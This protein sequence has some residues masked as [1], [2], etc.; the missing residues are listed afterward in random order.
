M[1]ALSKVLRDYV[2]SPGRLGISFWCPGCGRRHGVT[3]TDDGAWQ[4]DGNAD[5]PTISPSI[6]VR[7]TMPIKDED[8]AAWMRDRTPLPPPIPYVCHS[9]VT[10][11]QIQFLND[12]T[13]HLAGQT[14]P[15]PEF[16]EV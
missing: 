7:G 10:N 15:L 12:C 3:Y 11:G 4:W 8:H 9:F 13:H 16:P 6:L 5:S 14:V 2:Y 1:S